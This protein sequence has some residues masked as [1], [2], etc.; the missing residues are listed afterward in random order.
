MTKTQLK[1]HIEKLNMSQ[2]QFAKAIGYTPMAISNYVTGKR[3][4]PAHMEITIKGLKK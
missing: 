2:R 4:V 1:K 3:P